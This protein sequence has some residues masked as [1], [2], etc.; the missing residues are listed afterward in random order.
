M[1]G[2]A[3][4]SV[5]DNLKMKGYKMNMKNTA[6]VLILSA[7]SAFADNV[8]IVQWDIETGKLIPTPY[9]IQLRRGESVN[10]EPRFVSYAVPMNITGA[11]VDFRFW[12][13]GQSGYY[14]TT[15]SVMAATGRVHIAWYDALCPASNALNYEVRAT[16]GANV[17][18]RGYGSL[19]ILTGSTGQ[20]TNGTVYTQLNWQT[21][22]QLGGSAVLSNMM[23]SGS[24]WSGTQWT[25]AGVTPAAIVAAGGLTNVTQAQ[26]GAAGGLTNLTAAQI[27]AAGGLTNVTSAA[28]I[29]AG[30]LTNVTSA[31][32][33][34]AGGLT[35]VT[36]GQIVEAGGLTN[37]TSA[38]IVAAG[39]LTNVTGA[40][41][42]GA[43][44]LTNVSTAAVVG[45]G[46]LTNVTQAQIGTAGGLTNITQDMIGQAGGL[47]NDPGWLL[48]A[49]G[50]M[51]GIL[52]MGGNSI[53]N[54]GTNSLTF[55]DGTKV[56]VFSNGVL[57]VSAGGTNALKTVVDSG[58]IEAYAPAAPTYYADGSTLRKVGTTFSVQP[59]IQNNL[60]KLW[61]AATIDGLI[62]GTSF[63]DGPSYLFTDQNGV[64]L[65]LSTNQTWADSGYKNETS[66]GSTNSLGALVA[67][68]KLN[69]NAANTTV[70]DSSGTNNGT[71]AENTVDRTVT[72]KVNTAFSFNG[73]TD[74]ISIP[75]AANVDGSGS[76]SIALWFKTDSD[77]RTL[78]YQGNDG[79]NEIALEINP[80]GASAP[81]LLGLSL[82]EGGYYNLVGTNVVDDNA[83]HYGVAVKDG[84]NGFLYVDGVLEGTGPL[85]DVLSTTTSY[86]GVQRYGGTSD[87]WMVG[88]LDDVRIYQN[89]LNSNQVALLYNAGAGTEDYSDDLSYSVSTMYLT[90]TNKVLSFTAS[91]AI[92]TTILYTTNA[93]ALTTNDLQLGMVDMVSGATNWSSSVSLLDS[94]D[95]S[96]Q[97]YTA[98][99]I[100]V[101]GSNLAPIVWVSSNVSVTVK[102][103]AA[104]CAP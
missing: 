100:T 58:N 85:P 50:T 56:S 31:A 40:M 9:N 16:I 74:Y 83:W 102:G 27:Q 53:T 45:A 97:L 43:G 46:G 28:I 55:M 67:Y 52:D 57:G 4:R 103:M 64:L 69:D 11:V 33:V 84:T 91:N 71:L 15:G 24:T 21:L 65:T 25:F 1:E 35:N 32:V 92:P 54:I 23:G 22:N 87:R 86:L 47:T 78:Y 18:A 39:G 41:I 94:T 10:Y 29:A 93:V 98:S 19:T 38:A 63:L 59:W 12:Y 34:A 104:P 51:S 79:N 8:P 48:K 68:Y 49:G 75:S 81:H 30:G 37:I 90:A 66:I 76:Y 72:G 2:D 77:S 36:G 6:A 3:V 61:Y 20:A 7:L 60:I 44:G 101:G 82:Y 99:A 14:S 96:N 42:A 80:R 5:I 17:L 26:I 73:N 70:I 88:T 89:A 13:S 62:N 95:V